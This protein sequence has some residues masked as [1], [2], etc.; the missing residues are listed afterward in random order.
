MI[1]LIVVGILLG[2]LSVVGCDNAPQQPIEQETSKEE[3]V[4][5]TGVNKGVGSNSIEDAQEIIKMTMNTMPISPRSML[6]GLIGQG[7]SEEVAIE[8]VNSMNF[9]WNEVALK[10]GK[11]WVEMGFDTPEK[12]RLLMEQSWFATSNI[13]HTIDRM[14]R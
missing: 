1:K 7:Y 2:A 3:F 6:S 10:Y 11:H 5:D 9:N 13:D 14:F 8:A 4:I 12:L